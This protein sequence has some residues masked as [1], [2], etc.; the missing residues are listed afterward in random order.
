[1]SYKENSEININ[2]QDPLYGQTYL[3]VL[4]QTRS[5]LFDLFLSKNPNPNIQNNDGKTPIFYA[6]DINTV[7][8]LIEHGASVL[9]LDIDGKT[10][11]QTNPQIMADFITDK[12]KLR[13]D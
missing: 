13:I 4:V 12:L 7:K 11:N 2:Y 3:H 9:I 1:M 10:V 8:K 6:K 5:P